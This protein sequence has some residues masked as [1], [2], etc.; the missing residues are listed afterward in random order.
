MNGEYNTFNWNTWV[1]QNHQGRRR[2]KRMTAPTDFNNRVEHYYKTSEIFTNP[3]LTMYYIMINILSY[4]P[5][6]AYIRPKR[7]PFVD[8]PLTVPGWW[9]A[10]SNSPPRRLFAEWKI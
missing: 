3:L 9:T 7:I 6:F 2:A 10:P 4:A 8:G 1:H 5:G